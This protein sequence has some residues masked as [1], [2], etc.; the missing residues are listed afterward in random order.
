MPVFL[1]HDQREV[2]EVEGSVAAVPFDT[3]ELAVD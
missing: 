1:G 2:R 3:A